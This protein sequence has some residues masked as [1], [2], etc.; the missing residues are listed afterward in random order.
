MCVI[1]G[2]IARVAATKLFGCP[3]ADKTRQLTV[4][5][6]AVDTPAENVMLLPVP[7]PDSVVLETVHKDL[8]EECENSFSRG[9]GES[10]SLIPMCASAG[11][12]LA[13][14]DH[15]S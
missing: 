1:D 11:G 6:N 10:D 3:T 5:S 15:G 9:R 8:F 12:Y 14:R 4:Y 13:V 2:P 7:H